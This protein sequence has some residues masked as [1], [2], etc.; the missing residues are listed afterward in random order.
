MGGKIPISSPAGIA[1]SDRRNRRRLIVTFVATA[2]VV[3]VA[4]LTLTA[5]GGWA[6]LIH[7]TCQRETRVVTLANYYIPAVLVNSPYGGQAW[8]NG[9]F[10]PT[11]PG[12]S[13]GPPGPGVKAIAYGTGAIDGNALGAFFTVNVSIYQLGNATQWGPGANVRCTQPYGAFLSSPS[14]Y[15]EAGGQM[16]G[17]NNTSDAHEPPQAA[18]PVP[19]QDQAMTVLFNNGF[20]SD[21]AANVSTCGRPAQ[22]VPSVAS[23]HLSVWFPITIAGKILRVPY[24]IPVL[25]SYHYDFP[26]NFGT[27]QVDNLTAPGGPGGGWA[28]SYSPCP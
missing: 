11:F 2:A 8:G 24:V 9:T 23:G 13:N 12:I 17:L 6:P 4:L 22:S 3:V 10:S 21:N 1:P 25:E 16:L 7:W 27:W 28:F 15:V 14:I 19:I 20:H 18:L 5:I 26:A